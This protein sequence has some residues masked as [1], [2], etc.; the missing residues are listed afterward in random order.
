MSSEPA[1]RLEGV[2]RRFG[3]GEPALEI[4]R[5]VNLSLRPGELGALVGP[6]RAG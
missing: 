4:L 3:S 1:L 6:S 2:T 5:G